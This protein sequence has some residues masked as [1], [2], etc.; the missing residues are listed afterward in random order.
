MGPGAYI[1]RAIFAD[2]VRNGKVSKRLFRCDP[3]DHGLSVTHCNGTITNEEALRNYF[4]AF[5]MAVGLCII[6]AEDIAAAE[7]AVNP[8]PVDPPTCLDPPT[9]VYDDLHHLIQ[10][11]P[12]DLAR[13]VL[14]KAAEQRK[15]IFLRPL[16]AGS[17]GP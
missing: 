17:N 4:E 12:D 3:G 11:C 5:P 14:S 10:P 9:K 2:Q 6:R 16:E 15:L 13:R 8:D 1:R 7:L